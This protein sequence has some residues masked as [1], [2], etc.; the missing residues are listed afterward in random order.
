MSI[1]ILHGPNLDLLG[2]REVD[3]YGTTTLAG[4]TAD[5]DALARELGVDLVHHQSNHE[6]ELIDWIRAADEG[7][8]INAAGYTHTSVAIAD[9]LVARQ[10]P[11]VE[12]HLSNVHAREPFRRTSVIAAHALGVCT[13]FGPMSYRLGLRALVSHLRAGP[14]P[15]R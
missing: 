11:Y 2:T 5:L 8:V 14:A 9:S 12:V 3:I 13:G 1:S 7:I 4:I 10:L 15:S 6:G